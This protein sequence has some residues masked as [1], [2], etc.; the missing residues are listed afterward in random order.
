MRKLIWPFFI[1]ILSSSA[2]GGSWFRAL[3]LA[4]D[5]LKKPANDKVRD[6]RLLE[7][8]KRASP[9]KK[10]EKKEPEEP[11]AKPQQD[12]TATEPKVTRQRIAEHETVMTGPKTSVQFTRYDKQ[13]Y[14][15]ITISHRIKSNL[16]KSGFKTTVLTKIPNKSNFQ[17]TRIGDNH[18]V[19]VK[20]HLPDGG[21]Y[22]ETF[23]VDSKGQVV[24]RISEE[25]SQA[26]GKATINLVEPKKFSLNIKKGSHSIVRDEVD[27]TQQIAGDISHISVDEVDLSTLKVFTKDGEVHIYDVNLDNGHLSKRAGNNPRD[28]DSFEKT[29][30]PWAW[31]QEK[32]AGSSDPK[33]ITGPLGGMKFGDR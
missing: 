21:T 31:K 22:K 6:V 15:E 14:S 12:D 8:K 5:V 13:P 3:D 29:K 27:L 32:L 28:T 20:S 1:L 30:F 26:N 9:E 19:T 23:N 4:S 2:Y 33:E 18:F 25:F 10:T 7:P 11:K 24:Q 17:A 16:E